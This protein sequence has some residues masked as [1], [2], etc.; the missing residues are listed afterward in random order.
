MTI[1]YRRGK[2]D[3]AAAI[4]GV[5]R[6]SFC[7]TFAHLYRPQDL[8]A[9]LGEF[10]LSTWKAELQDDGFAFQVAEVD[11]Q[12]VGYVKLGP[13]ALPVET[14]GASVELRQLYLLKE[15]HGLGAAKALMDWAIGE[16]RARGGTE[17]YLTVYVENERA[18]RLYERFGFVEVGPYHFMVGEQAD[19]DIIMKL[20]L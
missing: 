5:F 19:E 9:F 18:R 6:T 14:A 3:D 13:P 4:D 11:G 20:A 10:A 12:V 15:W 2:V 16:A 7:D 1:S 8:A 17:L